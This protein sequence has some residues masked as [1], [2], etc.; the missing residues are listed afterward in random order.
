MG[1]VNVCPARCSIQL[2]YS[3]TNSYIHILLLWLLFGVLVLYPCTL[4]PLTLLLTEIWGSLVKFITC[5]TYK[6]K[7]LVQYVHCLIPGTWE[8]ARFVAILGLCKHVCTLHLAIYVCLTQ[9]SFHC[10]FPSKSPNVYAHAM[11]SDL[12]QPST[13]CTWWILPGSLI[14]LHASLKNR[15]EPGNKATRSHWVSPCY[16]SSWD[17]PLLYKIHLVHHAHHS[18]LITK[19]IKIHVCVSMYKCECVCICICTCKCACVRCKRN[20]SF[21]PL[22][23]VASKGLTI[24]QINCHMTRK[25]HHQDIS[26]LQNTV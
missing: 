17:F 25:N 11:P 6:W 10:T 24:K 14:L 5:M 1:D 16:G 26:H 7:G 18:L 21:N 12:V 9:L 15:E 19:R 8:V 22:I 3:E 2:C 13:S 20:L 4:A 23:T